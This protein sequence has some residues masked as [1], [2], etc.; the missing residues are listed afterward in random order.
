MTNLNYHFQTDGNIVITHDDVIDKKAEQ[1]AETDHTLPINY[2]F[3]RYD[4]QTL[5]YLHDRAVYSANTA[6]AIE[7][8]KCEQHIIASIKAQLAT[9]KQ[10]APSNPPAITTSALRNN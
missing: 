1:H 7:Y 5:G 3:E 6:F 2:N 10:P 9:A 4:F 8:L